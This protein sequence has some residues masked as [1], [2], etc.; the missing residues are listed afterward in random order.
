MKLP[1]Q[2][3][4]VIRRLSFESIEASQNIL[5]AVSCQSDDGSESCSCNTKCCKG[6]TWCDCDADCNY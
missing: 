6:D 2:S 4:P 1:I 3:A 5:P